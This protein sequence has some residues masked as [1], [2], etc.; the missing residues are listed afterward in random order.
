MSKKSNAPTGAVKPKTRWLDGSKYLDVNELAKSPPFRAKIE[1]TQKLEEGI[2]A[3]A[4]Q[5]DV[6]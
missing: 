3:Q 4:R 5:S 2:R 6:D 1:Q